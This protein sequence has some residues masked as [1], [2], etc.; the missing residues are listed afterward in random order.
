[1][2]SLRS[3]TTN[4]GT[5]LG[6]SLL[7]A[8]APAREGTRVSH[9]KSHHPHFLLNPDITN[10]WLIR[11]DLIHTQN[12][13]QHAETGERRTCVVWASLGRVGV[14]RGA[15]SYDSVTKFTRRH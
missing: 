1:V 7:L 15:C 3:S 2:C 12:P 6:G 14:K 4:E 13:R 5:A 9:V 10:E 11:F 8:N